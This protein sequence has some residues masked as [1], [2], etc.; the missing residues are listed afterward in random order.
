MNTLKENIKFVLYKRKMT[1]VDLAKKMGVSRQQIQSYLNGNPSAETLR[2]IA[3]ALDTTVDTI[4]AETPL[5][6]REDPI[7]TRSNI[8]ATKLVCP[9]CGQEIII[10]AK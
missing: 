8:T 1:Q 5:Y 3:I 2:K 10:T 7:P 6:I 9:H 4:T